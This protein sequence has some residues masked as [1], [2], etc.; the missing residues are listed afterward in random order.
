MGVASLV[1][2]KAPERVSVQLGIL[3]ECGL[4]RREIAK[5]A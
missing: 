1:S 2:V 5:V 3:S 4:C